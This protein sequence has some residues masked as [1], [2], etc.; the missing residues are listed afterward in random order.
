MPTPALTLVPPGNVGSTAGTPVSFALHA[1]GGTGSYTWTSSRLP[2]GLVLNGTTG[3]ISGTPTTAGSFA[4]SVT[5]RSGPKSASA[6]FTWTVAGQPCAAGQ[7]LGNGGFES[8]TSPWTATS[9]VVSSNTEAPQAHGGT[10]Y[11]WLGGYGIAHTDTVSQTVTVPVGCHSAT[12]T[13]WLQIS[14]ADTGTTGR[15]VMQVKVGT[16]VLASY[17]N[18]NRTGYVQRSFNLASY[19]GRTITITF[20][21]TEDASKATSFIVDVLNSVAPGA[22][23]WLRA[24]WQPPHS[25]RSPRRTPAARL[26]SD[27]RR[28]ASARSRAGR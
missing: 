13:F 22:A 3:I 2:T 17:S 8:G 14:S 5:V 15:D 9:G 20:S 7:L 26:G 1:S 21:G 24:P 12:L 27:R 18:V 23:A 11:A 16:A 28:S 10:H 4:I 19:A 25:S 6:S